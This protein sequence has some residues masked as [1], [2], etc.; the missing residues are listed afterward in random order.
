MT[1]RKRSARE[2]L[3]QDFFSSLGG[4][5]DVF[6]RESGRADA[7]AQAREAARIERSCS[8]KARY[9]TR[10]EA[11]EAIAACEAHGTRGLSCYRCPHCHGWHLT[12]HPWE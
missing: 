1:S 8:S 9:S 3:K 2:K 10:G 12:S 7:L 6:E 5:D 11:L 4:M